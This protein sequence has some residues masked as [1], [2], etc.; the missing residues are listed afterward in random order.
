V[1]DDVYPHAFSLNIE[2]M[3]TLNNNKPVWVRD[4]EHGFILGRICDIATDNVTVQLNDNRKVL[5]LIQKNNN[6]CCFFFLE[7][8][9]TVWIG[10]SS[11]R[12]R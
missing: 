10:I 11:G 2:N 7:R 6:L 4:N 3:I 12:I 1:S 5:N 8:C 9:C